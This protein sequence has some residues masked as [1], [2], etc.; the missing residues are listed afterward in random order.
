MNLITVEEQERKAYIEGSPLQ[1]VLAALDDALADVGGM[2]AYNE[3][4]E[5]GR[6]YEN[7]RCKLVIARLSD[8]RLTEIYNKANDSTAKT[9][10]LTTANIFR[11]MRA[12]MGA[13]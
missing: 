10:P 1:P 9:Q 6:E 13:L 7:E 12:V 8:E 2:A 3:G 11:A 4:K 5:A